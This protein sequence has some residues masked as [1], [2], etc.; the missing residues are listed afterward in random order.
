MA[1]YTLLSQ[2]PHAEIIQEPL[3]PT[4]FLFLQCVPSD[5]QCL[6]QGLSDCSAGRMAGLLLI[7]SQHLTRQHHDIS[8]PHKHNVQV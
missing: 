5:T 2:F 8:D 6:P 7:Y 1:E 4:H 3:Y